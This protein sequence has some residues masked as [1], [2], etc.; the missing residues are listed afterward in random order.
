MLREGLGGDVVEEVCGI[1][2]G[3]NN[4]ILTLMEEGRGF[5]EALREAQ[6][7]GYAETD[8]TMDVE[9]WDAAA[10]ACIIAN[11]VM[12]GR[13]KPRDVEREGITAVTVEDLERA[14]SSGRRL[15]HVVRVWREGGEVHAK[16]GVEELPLSSPLSSVMG[17]R[18]ALLARTRSLG[19]VFVSGPGAG[20]LETGQ[21]VL[22]DIVAVYRL[23]YR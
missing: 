19:E 7:L 13:V 3:T 4:F 20:G 15:K 23:H 22:S 14:L 9:G 18:N 5:R 21:A 2:N 8:P 16:V 6:R 10:K 11:A 17:V 1:L 12:G